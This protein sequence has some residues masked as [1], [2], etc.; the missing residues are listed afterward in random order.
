MKHTLQLGV[1]LLIPK[2]QHSI[3]LLV[4]ISR[5][6]PILAFLLPRGML[7]AVEF[8]NQVLRDAAEIGKVGTSPMLAA[9]FEPATA[10]GSEVRPQLA[11]LVS[12]LGPKTPA[13]IARSFV[14]GTQKA[15]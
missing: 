6:Q 8:D 1:H 15:R 12:G 7:T 4:E 13:A 11:L 9:E 14:F 10:L 5:S 3:T 2:P